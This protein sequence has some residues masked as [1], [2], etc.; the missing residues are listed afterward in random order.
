[1][2]KRQGEDRSATNY[3]RDI[4]EKEEIMPRDC[5]IPRGKGD[6][7]STQ[8]P[9]LATDLLKEQKEKR[10]TGRKVFGVWWGGI[11]LTDGTVTGRGRW[12]DA[13]STKGC[14][15]AWAIGFSQSIKNLRRNWEGIM[16][17]GEQGEEGGQ[18]PIAVEAGRENEKTNRRAL[19]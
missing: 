10:L 8:P 6:A 7:T 9:V 14:Q 19:E 5:R 11:F 15:A 1:V 18:E 3:K 17:G 4:S 2:T 13:S 12:L 16:A